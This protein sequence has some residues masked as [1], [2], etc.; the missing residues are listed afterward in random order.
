MGVPG[1]KKVPG[2]RYAD[3]GATRLPGIAWGIG[4]GCE[5]VS[6]AVDLS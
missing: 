6:R 4:I 1:K 5:K 2:M 3:L